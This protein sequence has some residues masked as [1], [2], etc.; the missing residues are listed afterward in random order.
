MKTIAIGLAAAL[1]AG[2]ALAAPPANLAPK[3]VSG[4]GWNVMDL[5]AQKAWYEQKLGM[6]VARTYNRDGKVYEYIMGFDGA[7]DGAAILAL[8]AS[9]QRKP[10][11][12]SAGRLILRVPDSK[13]LADWLGTQGVTARMVAPG[14][15]FIADPEGN[16]IE[17][18][19]PPP[20]AK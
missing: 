4:W 5:E 14:A 11:P 13:A 1:L 9:A 20:P 8:L 6:K 10:G 12:S 17:L 2:P 16:P 3:T 15:Y 18:Y 7:P 19:T